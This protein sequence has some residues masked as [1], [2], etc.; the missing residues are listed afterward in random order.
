MKI[1]ACDSVLVTK[2][3][4]KKFKK[5]LDPDIMS[6]FTLVSRWEKRKVENGGKIDDSCGFKKGD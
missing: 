6:Y 5:P 4:L 2:K 3:F 1:L